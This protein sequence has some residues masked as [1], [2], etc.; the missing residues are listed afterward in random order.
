MVTKRLVFLLVIV[1]LF[2]FLIKLKF[3]KFINFLAYFPSCRSLEVLREVL[4]FTYFSITA[5]VTTSR[6][7]KQFRVVETTFLPSFPSPDCP[8]F[9]DEVLTVKLSTKKAKITSVE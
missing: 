3:F 7:F 9:V 6:S 4:L 5:K 1:V 2:C 8:F